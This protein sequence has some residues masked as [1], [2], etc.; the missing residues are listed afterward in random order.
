[1]SLMGYRLSF[2]KVLPAFYPSV[3]SVHIPE[4]PPH[5]ASQ[6]HTHQQSKGM[7]IIKIMLTYNLPS[8]TAQRKRRWTKNEIGM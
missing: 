3:I 6:S 1:M 5:I 7:Y 2:Y 8:N 4:R